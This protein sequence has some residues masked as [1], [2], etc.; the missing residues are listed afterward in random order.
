MDRWNSDFR[1]NRIRY[2]WNNDRFLWIWKC[3][4]QIRSRG[5]II[6]WFGIERKRNGW[7]IWKRG[8]GRLS[9]ERSLIFFKHLEF[10]ELVGVCNRFLEEYE[11]LFVRF[12]VA[13]LGV[14]Q[15]FLSLMHHEGCK[16]C[17]IVAFTEKLLDE[18]MV[19]FVFFHV[20]LK[21]A[22]PLGLLRNR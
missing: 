21:F 3:V 22:Q 2:R 6:K 4:I 16:Y 15:P 10:I 1:K 13:D 8:V 18:Q 7:E 11:H 9:G 17:G 5:G 12:F 19:E 14:S 20:G